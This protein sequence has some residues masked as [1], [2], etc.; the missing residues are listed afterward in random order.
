M[1]WDEYHEMMERYL[2]MEMPESEKAQFE[3]RLQEDSELRRL[4]LHHKNLRHAIANRHKLEFLRKLKKAEKT[5]FKKNGLIRFSLVFKYAAAAA[6]V[7]L[8]GLGIYLLQKDRSRTNQELFNKYFSSYTS[9]IENRDAENR[10]LL[11]TK[12]MTAY[13]KGEFQESI[14]LFEQLIGHPAYS[15]PAAFYT[16]LSYLELRKADQAVKYLK[17]TTSY[18]S[19]FKLEAQWYLSLAYLL[20]NKKEQAAE[21]LVS[22]ESD[23][24]HYY[25]EKAQKLLRQIR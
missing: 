25:R 24:D 8:I 4:F 13:S 6:F 23:P 15:T 19:I 22:I 14:H 9:I 7:V 20:A 1:N 12:G 11:L 10:S 2:N 3:K 18:D 16:G 17:M 21:L 5:Y